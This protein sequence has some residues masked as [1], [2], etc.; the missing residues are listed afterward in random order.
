MSVCPTNNNIIHAM[1]KLLVVTLYA[2]IISASICFLKFSENSC[3]QEVTHC[4]MTWVV[5]EMS[6]PAAFMLVITGASCLDL[7][8]RG[9]LH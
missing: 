2:R 8:S 6:Y 9:I 5:R 1:V 7:T 4:Y 3:L